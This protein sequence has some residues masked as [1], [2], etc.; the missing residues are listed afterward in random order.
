MQ[1]VSAVIDFMF[2]VDEDGDAL[3]PSKFEDV[4][5]VEKAQVRP[6]GA[7]KVRDE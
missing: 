7:Q 1:R 4:D 3:P 2:K 5:A 6:V